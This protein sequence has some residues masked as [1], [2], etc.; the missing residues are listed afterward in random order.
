MG[1]LLLDNGQSC[2]VGVRYRGVWESM[3]AIILFGESVL[4]V[5]VNV[6]SRG[7]WSLNLLEPGMAGYATLAEIEIS[8]R[9]G[10]GMLV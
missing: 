6:A 8:L 9:V 2:S 3:L 7:T 4:A 1:T 5:G 10:L